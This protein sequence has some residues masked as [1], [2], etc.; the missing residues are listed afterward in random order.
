MPATD[1]IQQ[2]IA[3]LS[4]RVDAVPSMLKQ[5]RDMWR[6]LGLRPVRNVI[7]S[8]AGGSEGPA[9]A[10]NAQ[11]NRQPQRGA[12]RSQFWPLSTFVSAPS[13]DPD[14]LLVVFSQGLSHNARVALRHHRRFAQCVIITTVDASRADERGSYLQQLLREGALQ[15]LH[16]PTSEDS[17]LVRILGPAAMTLIANLLAAQLNDEPL[18]RTLEACDEML[19]TLAAAPP[20]SQHLEATADRGRLAL[21]STSDTLSLMHG[22]R[23]KLLEG[24][25]DDD[26]TVWDVLQFAHG[27]LQSIYQRRATLLGFTH[28]QHPRAAELLELLRQVLVPARHTLILVE[29]KLALPWSFFE[30]DM[31]LNRV[32]L[33]SIQHEPRLLTQ[34]PAQ[35]RDEPLY[36]FSGTHEP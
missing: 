17:L 19:A 20:L 3:I 1:D 15:I 5:Q 34:W 7:T 16:L 32:M 10:L 13:P 24:L 9:R 33:N 8:G 18:K 30:H 26:P 28:A 21:I 11:L 29:A 6:P 35:G 27:P 36:G 22:L 2:S 14:T 31:W 12:V 4:R 25:G 23:W